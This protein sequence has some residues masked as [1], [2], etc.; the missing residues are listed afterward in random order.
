MTPSA[1]QALRARIGKVCISL[2]A[3]TSAEMLAKASAALVDCNFLEFRLDTLAEPDP[4]AFQLFFAENPDLTAIATCRRAEYGG[5]FPD[6]LAQEFGLLTTAAHVGFHI[7]DLELES[8]EALTVAQLTSLRTAGAALLLSH[9]NF[10]ATEDLEAIYAR[11]AAFTPDFLKI[12]PTATTLAD[13][14]QVRHLLERHASEAQIVAIAMGEPGILSR[15]LSPRWGGAFTF[16]SASQGAETAPGQIDAR[17]LLDLYGIDKIDAATKFYGVV[18]NPVRSS[19]SPLMLNTAFRRKD[20]N[21]VYLP[22][23]TSTL[24]DLLQL[25]R[26]LPLNGLSVTMPFKQ[27]IL[28][29]LETIAPL[30]AQIGACNTVLRVSDG[31]LHGFNTDVAGIIGPLEKRMPLKDARVLVLGAGGAARAAAFGLKDKGSKVLLLNRT[32]E[33]A[34]K[35]ARQAGVQ[36]LTRE[37]LP[38]TRVDIIVNAT[39]I[40][41]T[42]QTTG[43]P[44]EAHELAALTPKLVFDLV[45]NPLETPLLR[46][47]REQ[48]IATITGVEMFVHQG[49]R[50]FELWTGKAA[51]E[52]E[53]L[54]VVLQTLRQQKGHAI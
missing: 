46:F 39:P 40:G 52:D 12:V 31:K 34:Q 18:G 54:Q 47:V 19:L 2:S 44:L 11:I 49:A 41:M 1:A 50:Q 4:A 21:A 14:L 53:M 24:P 32:R 3:Q 5:H 15:I 37:A 9:H 33:T 51:P 35:L 10:T 8:A 25:V 27:Q 13:N 36:V 26:D 22:L 30:A 23:Q 20:I 45:Y 7:L 17:T 38:R 42:G 43:S 28:P 6:T 48:S 16:A 29:Y